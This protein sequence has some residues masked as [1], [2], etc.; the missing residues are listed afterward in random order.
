MHEDHGVEL[1]KL[2]KGELFDIKAG[3]RCGVG[4]YGAEALEPMH[5]MRKYYPKE[6]LPENEEDTTWT[7]DRIPFCQAWGWHH[8]WYDRPDT[9]HGWIQATHHHQEW[10]VRFMHEAFRRRADIINS[11]TIHLLINSRPNNWLKALCSFDREPMPGF[12]AFADAN[13]PVVVNLRTDRH[14]LTGGEPIEAELWLLNDT[15]REQRGLEA[16]YRV[17]REGEVL[18][19]GRCPVGVDR[20]N[21]GFQG[22][23]DW[24]TPRVSEPTRLDLIASLLKEDGQVIHDY[25]LTVTLY[26]QIDRHLLAGRKVAVLGLPGGRGWEVAQFFGGTPESWETGG[27]PDLLILDEARMAHAVAGPLN[28]FLEV[29]GVAL[30][31]PQPSGESW[32]IGAGGITVRESR[33]HQF[34]S[35]KTGHPIVEGFDPFFYSFWYQPELDRITHLM[36]AGIEGEGLRPVTLSGMGLWYR[37]RE[38]FAVTAERPLGS[39]TAIFDQVRAYERLGSEPR[40]GIHL[41]RVLSFLL[42]SKGSS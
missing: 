28:E 9:I 15:P 27:H 17:E 12:F 8:Q 7:P 24:T 20:L 10:A 1:G 13:T 18:M 11:T 37:A 34:V 23:L 4:E 19:V 3:W 14:A 2:H 21:A 29:G 6:W 36:D 33:S 31:L 32:P 26:P 35:R 38:E 25:R 40:A 22:K 41:Q 39:G 30:A 5:T 16:V 42:E